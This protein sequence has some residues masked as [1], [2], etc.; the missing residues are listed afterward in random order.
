MSNAEER[1]V[2]EDGGGEA[3]RVSVTPKAQVLPGLP[4][5]IIEYFPPGPSET[6]RD[7]QY[8]GVTYSKGSVVRQAD[9]ALYTCTGDKDGSWKKTSD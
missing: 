5:R 8:G 6:S 1:V 4:S 9:N 3:P 2:D 7:C